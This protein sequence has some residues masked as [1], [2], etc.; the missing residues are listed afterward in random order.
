MPTDLSVGV[1]ASL[2]MKS[3]RRGMVRVREALGPNAV[4]ETPAEYRPYADA[5]FKA[6]LYDFR[7]GH[8]ISWV[9]ATMYLLLGAMILFTRDE[10]PEGAGTVLVIS[11][12]FTDTVGQ[13][14]FP[15]FIAGAFA[16]LFSTVLIIF[17]GFPRTFAA[18]LTNIFAPRADR[19]WWSERSL[20]LFMMGVMVV[21]AIVALTV[22]PNPAWL[23]PAAGTVSFAISP[24]LFGINL[25]IALKFIPER[26]RPSRFVVAWSWVSIVVLSLLTLWIIPQTLGWI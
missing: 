17:D 26:Y 3:K 8:I 14:M 9:I 15:V 20:M 18:S 22:F 6:A 11:N 19:P 13:W 23:V 2:W 12:I 16:A 4:E 1:W 21:F 7:I 5:W 25:Y 10:K 24:V